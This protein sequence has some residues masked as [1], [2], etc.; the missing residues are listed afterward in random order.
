M[1]YDAEGQYEFEERIAM[2]CEAGYDLA[3]ADHLARVDLSHR[4]EEEAKYVLLQAASEIERLIA[5]RGRIAE[6]WKREISTERSKALRERWADLS[7][8]IAKIKCK[9]PDDDNDGRVSG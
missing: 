2:R 7:I 4:P 5:E 6:L 9:E 3:T 1:S 8:K